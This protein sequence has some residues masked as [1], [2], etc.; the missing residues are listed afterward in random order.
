ML[1]RLCEE[2]LRKQRI[3]DFGLRNILSV[4]RTA[5]ITKRGE[6]KTEEEMSLMRSLW[7]MNL[8]KLVAPDIPLFNN[9]LLDIFPK[10]PRYQKKGT[11]DV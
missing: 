1:Y 2:Q 8:L 9:L 6:Q 7:D 3:Y 4:L 5:G 10:K 11:H